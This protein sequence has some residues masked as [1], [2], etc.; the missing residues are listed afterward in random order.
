MRLAGQLD[1]LGFA[2][3]A[4]APPVEVAS[5]SAL[6]GAGAGRAG[7]HR[8]RALA[9]RVHPRAART[10]TSSARRAGL[11]RPVPPPPSLDKMVLPELDKLVHEV[12]K[13][14][15]LEQ[16]RIKAFDYFE[17]LLNNLGSA[18]DGCF[19]HDDVEDAAYLFDSGEALSKLGRLAQVGLTPGGCARRTLGKGVHQCQQ[20]E[21]LLT[22]TRRV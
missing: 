22:R 11:A 3:W 9:S 12:S 2:R 5:P 1:A 7:Y 19:E 20:R 18:P 6:A 4:N 15:L 10:R 16:L 13:I 14:E 8:G 17:V 21:P